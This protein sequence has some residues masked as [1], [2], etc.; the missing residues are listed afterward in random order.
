MV[1]VSICSMFLVI[2]IGLNKPEKKPGIE[3]T[4]NEKRQDLANNPT[5]PVEAAPS[6]SQPRP[7]RVHSSDEKEPLSNMP[8]L[9]SQEFV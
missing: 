5:Q 4:N 2:Q 3:K 7:W 1:I 6:A 9:G 8:L